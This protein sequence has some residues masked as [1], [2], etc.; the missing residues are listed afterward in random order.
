MKYLSLIICL[1]GLVSCDGHHKEH[2]LGKFIVGHPWRKKIQI[3]KE[4]VAQIHAI[5]HI[6]LR[7]YERGYLQQ[8]YVDEGQKIEKDQKMFQLMPLLMEAEYEKAKAEY[9]VAKI[10]YK[11]TSNLA[12]R[13]V[14]SKNELALSKARLNKAKAE[15]KLAQT[16][17]DFT[18][19][20]APFE[21]IM[22]RFHVRLG[23]LVEEGELLTSLSDNSTMWVY[24]NV[25][26]TDYLNFMGRKED[27]RSLPVTLLLANGE[28]FDQK[29]AIDTIEADFN[30]ETGNVAFRA[31][32]PN[33]QGLLRHG[34]TGSVVLRE[35]FD[36]SLVIPQKATFEVLDKKFVFVVD[37]DNVVHSREIEVTDDDVAH[38]FIVKSGLSEKDLVVMEGIKKIRHGS[39]IEKEIKE[40]KAIEDGLDL[41]VR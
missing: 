2:H 29:G 24:F 20:K 30:N 16:H 33:P 18:T 39:H 34:E 17:L 23:S 11:N 32:F 7:A 41:P 31:S 6:E 10:E 13:K 40:S 22:G 27:K 25:S 4:Y 21:G 14:V 3:E 9:D 26:E 8:T 19:I 1:L 5:Q 28:V 35:E 37:K 36:Q 38:L 12:K 15:L